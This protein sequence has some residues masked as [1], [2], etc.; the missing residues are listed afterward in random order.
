LQE[1]IVDELVIPRPGKWDKRWRIVAFDIPV[2]QSRSRQKFV[3]RLQ[4]L[5]FIMLQ[6]SLWVHPFP[7]FDQVE[8]LAGHYNVMRHCTFVEV[9]QLDELA[10]RRLLRRFTN[11][12]QA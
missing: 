4:T 11:L 7:C 1:V 6:K 12:L 5:N 2:T 9:S 10:A 3:D 8:Q